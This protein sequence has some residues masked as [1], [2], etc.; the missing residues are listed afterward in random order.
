MPDSPPAGDADLSTV[1]DLLDDEHARTILAATSAEPLSAREL[2]DRCG[3]SPSAVYRRVER[4]REASLLDDATRP[5][6]DGH[7]ETVYVAGFETFEL[8]VRDGDLTWSVEP[9]ES[10][11]ADE[12]TRLWGKF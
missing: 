4:L 3:L 1:T 9:P 7:H 11:V 2:S 10:D 6:P 5:R 12:L 8:T